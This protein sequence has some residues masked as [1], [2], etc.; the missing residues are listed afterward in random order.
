MV[1]DLIY[2]E[3]MFARNVDVFG[4][5]SPKEKHECQ[6]SRTCCCSIIALEPNEDCPIHGYPWPP[7]CEICGRFMKWKKNDN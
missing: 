1:V 3:N 6:A 5:I 4:K 7:R 2:L